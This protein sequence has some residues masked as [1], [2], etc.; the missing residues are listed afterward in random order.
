GF[1]LEELL[2]ARPVAPE[3]EQTPAQTEA[4]ATP[5]RTNEPHELHDHADEQA[6]II[7]PRQVFLARCVHRI[8]PA[9]GAQLG[10]ETAPQWD[11]LFVA[12][13]GWFDLFELAAFDVQL[14]GEAME[15]LLRQGTQFDRA[16][17]EQAIADVKTIRSGKFSLPERKA[18]PP[19]DPSTVKF[20]WVGEVSDVE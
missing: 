16:K 9:I 6:S 19:I 3:A 2:Q 13:N 8:A 1:D 18:E 14:I 7:D 11:K 10:S 5:E 17:V 12:R 15:Q 20:K 4:G